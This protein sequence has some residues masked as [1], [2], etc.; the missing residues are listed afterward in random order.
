MLWNEWSLCITS[1]AIPVLCSVD[2]FCVVSDYFV[3]KDKSVGWYFEGEA[4]IALNSFY[5]GKKTFFF[6]YLQTFPLQFHKQHKSLPFVFIWTVFDLSPFSKNGLLSENIHTQNL[7]SF[8]YSAT[9]FCLSLLHLT[10]EL[11]FTF[12]WKCFIVEEFDQV[13]HGAKRVKTRQRLTNS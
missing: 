10:S 3:Y 2:M 5:G 1:L 4:F 8:T 9:H 11:L 12:S 6:I 13:N 7:Q